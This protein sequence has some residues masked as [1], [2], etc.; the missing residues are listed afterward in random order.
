VNAKLPESARIEGPSI[1]DAE[2]PC[3][4]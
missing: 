1:D 3:C 4:S 2:P